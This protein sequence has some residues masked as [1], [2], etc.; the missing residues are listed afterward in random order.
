M[1]GQLLL[2]LMLSTLAIA[3][4]HEADFDEISPGEMLPQRAVLRD[5]LPRQDT[6]GYGQKC[7]TG[8]MPIVGNCCAPEGDY[9]V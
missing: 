6:C 7:G 9:Y 5:L 1:I 4:P 8:C 2:P 3:I